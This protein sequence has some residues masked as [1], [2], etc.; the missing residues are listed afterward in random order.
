MDQAKFKICFLADSHD[1]YDDRIYWKEAVS[2]KKAGF[3]LHIILAGNSD[4][5]GTS[6]EGIH[7]QFVKRDAYPSNPILNYLGK[8]TK[9][10]LYD[11][12]FKRASALK[13]AVYHIHDLKVN[14]LGK[15]L[16]QLPHSPA[17][18]Y[19]VHEPYPENILDYW[20]D[21]KYLSSV[22][23]F[24][25]SH[26]KKWEK[27]AVKSYD[28]IITTEENMQ[29]RF[30]EYYPEKSVEII[31]N[32]TNLSTEKST[33][34][35]EEKKY[36]LIY[37]GG[38]TKN[39]GA[40][41]ILDAVLLL[42]KEYP[43]IRTLFLGS[44]FP[45]DLK[46]EMREFINNNQL[47]QNIELKDAVPYKEMDSF[48]NESKIG[49][50]IFL[51]ILTHQIILQI[52]IFEYMNC[53]LP[54]VGSNFGHIKKFIEVHQCGLLVDPENPA[55]IANGVKDLLS[56]KE[57]YTKM[58]ENGYMAVKDNYRWEFMEEKLLGLYK[59]L[60]PIDA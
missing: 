24:W 59:Q 39:R 40:L 49:L 19:D 8:R 52:K 29:K 1:L 20:A 10:G 15:K 11:S 14:L 51:P 3:D 16:K 36:D 21:R 30:Q 58:S 22:R 23:K 54:I 4:D 34:K 50:G 60:L 13:A 9:G 42:K 31:Y 7:Y 12:M 57:E 27:N 25:S 41:K 5:Q 44:W 33:P 37:T 55:D 2:L 47:Q 26:I 17:V 38:I 35:A 46:S 53:G 56:N 6:A 48:Y 45:E 32:Y 28:L 18:I 43:D